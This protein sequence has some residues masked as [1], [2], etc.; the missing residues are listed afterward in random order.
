MPCLFITSTVTNSSSKYD[1]LKL[2]KHSLSRILIFSYSHH[3]ANARDIRPAVESITRLYDSWREIDSFEWYLRGTQNSD[4]CFRPLAIGHHLSQIRCMRLVR[5]GL[6]EHIRRL[7]ISRRLNRLTAVSNAYQR[8]ILRV[9]RIT[10]LI[11]HYLTADFNNFYKQ[12]TRSPQ[13]LTASRKL[14]VSKPK[15]RQ[16]KRSKMI[17]YK[18]Q[19]DAISSDSFSLCIY[20]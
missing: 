20:S 10:L 17:V 4:Y 16:M 1:A 5:T 15:L 12:E 11:N 13:Q 14:K 9:N 7:I 18:L 8:E 2:L 19:S 3:E 6:V